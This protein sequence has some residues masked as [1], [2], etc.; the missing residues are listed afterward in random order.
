MPISNSQMCT[1]PNPPPSRGSLQFLQRASP[2]TR[3]RHRFCGSTRQDVQD[4]RGAGVA[5]VCT[6][7]ANLLGHGVQAPPE[8][9]HSRQPSQTRRHR[10]RK[11]IP[12]AQTGATRLTAPS[13]RLVSI[14]S[15]CCGVVLTPRPS[16]RSNFTGCGVVLTTRPSPRSNLTGCGVV[17]TPRRPR[18]TR[19]S[20]GG[21]EEAAFPSH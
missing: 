1:A 6:L 10:A 3:S 20:E 19:R 17:L 18:S 13:W 4:V 11:G 2:V 15:T 8:E 14:C 5:A 16:P 9:L 12:R 21:W 7:W